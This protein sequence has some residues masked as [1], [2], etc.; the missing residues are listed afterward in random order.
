MI[1]L[2]KTKKTAGW[3]A[4]DTGADGLYGVTVLAPLTRDGKPR[5]VKCGVISGAVID[6]GAL[7][8]LAKKISINGC[9]WVLSLIHKEYKILVV[10]EPSVLSSEIEDSVRWSIGSMIDYPV[11]EANL[12]WI[13]IPTQSLLP[14]RP[15]HLYVM[16]AKSE[17]I[18]QCVNVFQ[19]A[20]INLQAVDIRETA[21][22]NI[23]ALTELPGEG[24]A[25]IK[26]DKQGAQSTITFNGE[27][28]LDRY[29]EESSLGKGLTD[30]DTKDRVGERIVLQTQRSLDFVART[31]G[32]ID[33]KRVLL[34]PSP[35]NLDFSD[36]LTQ[37][38]QVP[39]E[40]LDLASIFDF[41][42]TPELMQ[43][44]NQSLYFFALGAALRFMKKNEG[45][46]QHVNLLTQKK[47]EFNLALIAAVMLGLLLLSLFGL[48]SFRQSEVTATRQAEVAS[49]LRLQ[50]AK[51]KLQLL[52]AQIMQQSQASLSTEIANLKQKAE[53]AQ[54][55]LSQTGSLGSPQG[56]ARYFDALTSISEDG[57]WLTNVSVD[58]AGKSVR[59][60]GNALNKDSVMR[61]AQRLNERF[62]SDD[63]QF[64][65]LELTPVSAGKPNDPDS[66]VT[67]V[68][69]KLY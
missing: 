47:R 58:Q 31:L 13:Q 68:A 56:Y 66:Q 67:A 36:D 17:F 15:P 64:S 46:G 63:V 38:L 14:N 1:N 43:Q 62:S 3:T 69:F 44:E 50:Q 42:Q 59:V 52:E 32:F 33:I 45:L 16:A 20:K 30:A 40:K 19:K 28:Y 49:S 48:W 37:N 8:S 39:L 29:A 4:V 9:P 35:S 41:S 21:Q 34:A 53:A 57:L 5:V 24:V 2:H 65:A 27:L 22:R 7:T 10:E 60:S 25:L 61:Y 6:A 18:A 55:I 23:A 12:T 11:T 51:D 26:I 54:Q